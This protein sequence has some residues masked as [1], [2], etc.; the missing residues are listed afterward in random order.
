MRFSSRKFGI[1]NALNRDRP[2]TLPPTRNVTTVN[3]QNSRNIPKRRNTKNSKYRG[4][5]RIKSSGRWY[6][7]I[8]YNY[9]RY[10]LGSF[11]T[12]KQAARAYDKATRKYHKEFAR[13]NFPSS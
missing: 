4:V 7:E 1:E 3:V 5:K 2:L 8:G 6:A 9:K 10:Y 13:L 12:E 11:D